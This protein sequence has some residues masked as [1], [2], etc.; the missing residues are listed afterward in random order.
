MK[1]LLINPLSLN[2]DYKYMQYPLGLLYLKGVL[3]KDKHEVF[4]KDYTTNS[5]E[6]AKNEIISIIKTESIDLVGLTCTTNNRASAFYLTKLIKENFPQIKLVMGGIHATFLYK[7]ILENFPVDY[8]VLGEGEITFPELLKSI[9][10]KSDLKNIKG[11]AYKEKNEI[12][13]TGFQSFMADLNS[14]PFPEHAL[15]KDLINKSKTAFMMTSR[16]CPY[17]CVFCSTTLY[18]GRKWRAR[19][20]KNVVDEMEYIIK[21]FPDIGKI[22]FHDD[23]FTVDNNRVIEIC[24]EILKRKIL[25]KWDCSSRV[26]RISKEM[27]LKMKEAGCISVTYGIESGSEKILKAIEKGITKEDIKKALDATTEAGLDFNGYLMVGNPGETWDTI[28]ETVE[29]L[30]QFKKL[31]IASVSR[32]EIYPNTQIYDIAKQKGVIND[33]YWISD[34][35]PPIFTLEHSEEELTKMAYYII[36]HNQIK[37]GI[38]RFSIFALDQSIKRPKRAI[39]FVFSLFKKNKENSTDETLD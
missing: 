3:K 21:L 17:G 28:K 9:D 15:F 6:N 14:L 31:D 20:A 36:Y 38:I 10:K 30:S 32:L 16:G 22:T 18:W 19:S 13:F 23:T 39:N 34:K 25:V 11:L 1:I 37:K 2:H 24:N 12:V 29:F 8:I 35:K 26:D 7:K 33:D 4:I 27:L 5:P